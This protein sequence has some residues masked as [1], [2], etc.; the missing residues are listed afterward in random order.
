MT[1]MPTDIEMND[2]IKKIESEIKHHDPYFT[3]IPDRANEALKLVVWR[4]CTDLI[5]KKK[6]TKNKLR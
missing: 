4:W 2:L 1:A 6:E 5:Y 3:G